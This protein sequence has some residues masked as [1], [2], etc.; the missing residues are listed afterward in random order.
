VGQTNKWLTAVN[1]RSALPGNLPLFVFADAGTYYNAA[2][3]FSG[4]EA[5]MYDAGLMTSLFNGLFEFYLPLFAS[6]DI[7]QAADLSGIRFR[8]VYFSVKFRELSPL[9]LFKTLS[10]I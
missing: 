2:N 7:R 4:S 8:S 3:A 9:K 1:I 10:G 6:E 5:I